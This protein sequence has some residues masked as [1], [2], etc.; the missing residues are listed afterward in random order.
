MTRRRILFGVFSVALALA[1]AAAFVYWSPGPTVPAPQLSRASFDGVRDGMTLNE[2]IAVIGLPP[3]DYTIENP[4]F[5]PMD[6]GIAVV[7]SEKWVCDEARCLIWFG[8]DGKAWMVEVAESTAVYPRARPNRFQR[9][10]QRIG[11]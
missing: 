7:G 1:G 2:V 6:C 9:F 4:V 8:D 5:E 10:R 3:G 11:F